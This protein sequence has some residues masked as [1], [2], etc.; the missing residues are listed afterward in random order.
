MT[1]LA[2]SKAVTQVAPGLHGP[3]YRGGGIVT[4]AGISVLGR[5][6]LRPT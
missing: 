3:C 4:A 1:H 5:D 6:R 2:A